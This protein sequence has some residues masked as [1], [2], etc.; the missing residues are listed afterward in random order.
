M[1]MGKEKIVYTALERLEE[2]LH[3]KAEWRRDA[4]NEVLGG[5]IFLEFEGRK[6]TFNADIRKVL[7]NAQLPGLLQNVGKYQS[8]YL[9]IA[10]KIAPKV[11]EVLRKERIAYLERNGDI[12][13]NQVTQGGLLIFVDGNKPI[14]EKSD[15]TG[16]AF[17]KTGLKVVFHFLLEEELVNKPYREIAAQA[18][19]A[20]GNVTNVVNGLREAGFLLKE[21]KDRY[22]LV[23]KKELLTKWLTAYEEVLKPKLEIGRFRFAKEEYLYDWR[24]LPLSDQLSWWGGE[25]AANILTAYL[26]PEDFTL[27]TLE[28]K[29][30][31]MRRY[32]L[33]PDPAG[34]ICVYKKF[35]QGDYTIDHIAPPLLVYADL[36]STGDRR[37]IETAERIFD[38]YLQNRF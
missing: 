20:L 23:H 11:K 5:V 33:K 37:C 10:E 16:R 36:V 9:L 22:V 27:Y 8:G 3:C 1:N 15:L 34:N 26:K 38:E 13:I 19:T 2:T 31:L 29:S 30:E 32:R 24:S 21:R 35:W 14:V 4:A 17:T 28:T 7:H 12:Y 18:G 6:L 25:P